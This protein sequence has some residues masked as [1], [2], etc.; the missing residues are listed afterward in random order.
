PLCLPRSVV[1][2]PQWPSRSRALQWI[3]YVQYSY[4]LPS[5]IFFLAINLLDRFAAGCQQIANLNG[6]H[7]DVL[8]IACLWLAWKYESYNS[9]PRTEEIIAHSE[10]RLTRSQLI[11]AEWTV[12]NTIGLDLSYS[13]PITFARLKLVSCN[14]KRETAYV[15]RF[16]AE[17]LTTVR[18][19]VCCQPA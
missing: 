3:S 13:S 10:F 17:I 15:A 6:A 4:R 11:S 14:R 5:E 19:L 9:L 18:Q 8:G 2:I 16:L 1:A 7:W 12:R